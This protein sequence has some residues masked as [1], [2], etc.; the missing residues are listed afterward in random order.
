MT[1]SKKSLLKGSL[2]GSIGF[3]KWE[4]RRWYMVLFSHRD[5]PKERAMGLE[6][7]IMRHMC[8]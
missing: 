6:I 5:T 3:A 8:D 1:E 7:I 4:G 2:R